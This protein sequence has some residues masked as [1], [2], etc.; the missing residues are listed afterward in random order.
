MSI[1]IEAEYKL[2]KEET[3]EVAEEVE[4][5]NPDYKKIH[6][7]QL[8][9]RELKEVHSG[10]VIYTYRNLTTVQHILEDGDDAFLSWTQVE[11]SVIM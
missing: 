5:V 1:Q 10:I 11:S 2:V 3:I 7:I 6:K 4:Y 8:V 9:I